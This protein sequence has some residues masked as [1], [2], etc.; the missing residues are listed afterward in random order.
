MW[1]SG[2][3]LALEVDEGTSYQRGG[4]LHSRMGGRQEA[5]G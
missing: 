2:T 5:W 4:F 3:I 1:F